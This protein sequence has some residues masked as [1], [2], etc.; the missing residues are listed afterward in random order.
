LN[1]K[2][3]IGRKPEEFFEKKISWFKGVSQGD[4]ATIDP[5]LEEILGRRPKDGVEIVRE[6][7]QNNLEYD[8]PQNHFIKR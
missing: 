1:A 2:N 6:L 5:A 4:G 8:W 3:D 7:L